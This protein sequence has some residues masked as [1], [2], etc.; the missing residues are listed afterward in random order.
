MFS[1]MRNYWRDPG[2]WRWWWRECVSVWWWERVS[3]ATKV[4]LAMIVAVAFGIAGYLSAERL[5]ATQEA[6]TFTTQ[7]V[8]TVVRK[9]RATAP[10]LGVPASRRP[11]EVVTMVQMT[12]QP[13]G[14][15]VVTVRRAGRAVVV[16][17]PGET[18]T[19]ARTV[20]GSVQQRVVTNARTATVVRTETT[21]RPTTVTTPGP[22]QTV[23]RESTQT[24]TRESTQTV[25]RE[26]TQTVTRESTQTVTREKEVT[27]TE[28]VTETETVKKGP[29]GTTSAD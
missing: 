27:V 8:V 18:V 6:A 2:F 21:D 29:P 24:V 15:E 4:A 7:R 28:T 3:G 12:T 17:A 5:A 25:T 13:G 16:R 10:E 14:T 23:T 1:D 20:R 11:P 9:T 19:E 22:T 26:S